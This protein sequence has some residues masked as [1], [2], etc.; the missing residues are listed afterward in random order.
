MRSRVV[1]NDT[2]PVMAEK[3]CNRICDLNRGDCSI[4]VY[5]V[6]YC[7]TGDP[8]VA[9]TRWDTE[10]TTAATVYSRDSKESKSL[11]KIHIYNN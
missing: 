7:Y 1:V 2:D 4:W 6:P 5:D 9:T 8:L 11:F 10:A 3:V